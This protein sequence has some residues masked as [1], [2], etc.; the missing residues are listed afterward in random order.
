MP[1]KA[2]APPLA[3]LPATLLSYL[4]GQRLEASMHDLSSVR[5]QTLLDGFL[6]AFFAVDLGVRHCLD[7]AAEFG[8]F[9]RSRGWST[10]S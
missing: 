7:P 3:P 5:A 2:V 10:P 8:F 4:L 9:N 1:R 6:G